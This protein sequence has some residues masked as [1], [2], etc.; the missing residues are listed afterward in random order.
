[1]VRFAV[2]T[3]K[4][5]PVTTLLE[6]RRELVGSDKEK[7]ESLIYSLTCRQHCWTGVS[8]VVGS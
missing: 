2:R 5:R 1:M 8:A 3:V 6:V 4:E 7:C